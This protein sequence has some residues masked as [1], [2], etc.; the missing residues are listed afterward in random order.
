MRW[1]HQFS[2]A[3]TWSKV[4]GRLTIL[5]VLTMLSLASQAPS[6]SPGAWPSYGGNA[7]HQG[8]S[9]FRA[10][11]MD[12]ILWSRKVDLNPQYSGNDLLIHYGSPLITKNNTVVVPV[13]T[14]V[15]DG[16]RVDGYR[17]SDGLFLWSFATDYSLPAHNWTPSMSPTLVGNSQVA[18][19]GPGGTI[20]L[21]SNADSQ[22]AQ[23]QQL[24]F[25]GLNLYRRNQA[26]ANL[27]IKICTP[28]TADNS[29]NLYFGYRIS[30]NAPTSL[31]A[32]KSGI[33]RVN[34]KGA[35]T[36]TPATAAGQDS[37]LTLPVM[38]CAPALS[39]DGSTVYIGLRRTGNVFGAFGGALVGL[40]SK[41]LAFQYKAI[42]TDPVTSLDADMA[43]DGTASPIVGP[44]GD[45]FYGILENPF[46]SN[47][48]RGW[49]LHFDAALNQKGA[50]GAFGWDDAPSIVPAYAV[51]GYAGFSTYLLCTKY[52]NYASI[53]GNGLNRV[54]LLDPNDSQVE[55]YSGFNCMTEVQTVLGVTPDFAFPNFPGAVREWCINS[56]AI[57]PFSR[58]AIVN[59][60]DGIAYRWDFDSNSLTQAIT[61]TAGVG[62]AYT[63]TLIG[64]NGTVYA[65]NNA[66]LFAIGGQLQL[67]SFDL[68]QTTVIGGTP[69]TGT[70]RLNNLALSDFTVNLSANDPSVNFPSTVT[71]LAGTKQVSF[72]ITTSVVGSNTDVTIIA[73]DNHFVKRSVVLTLTP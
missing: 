39:V 22:K 52:N 35:G 9:H 56:A 16:F 32:L 64:A 57:D 40:N 53:G 6:Q 15:N 10:Q 46:A 50:P 33:A 14:G 8:I 44:D 69:V 11:S 70:V 71:I 63:P 3:Q 45:V 37:L 1:P 55:T 58:C 49:L 12:K 73:Q 18:I 34:I 60:E 29:G 25:Y 41:T 42:L 66:T 51:R 48:D 23:V 5:P 7:Q 65:I 72:P 19:P 21:R 43:D 17:G 59:C 30:G 38:N 2:N 4:L 31:S 68:D 13:K 36:W 47:N 62:E 28:V 24:C 27:N 20:Y 26:W 54:A 67:S 61:L